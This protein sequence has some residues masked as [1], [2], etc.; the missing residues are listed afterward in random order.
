[1]GE[2]PELVYKLDS[3][4]LIIEVRFDLSNTYIAGLSKSNNYSVQ[5]LYI[6]SVEYEKSATKP[7]RQIP[8]PKGQIPGLQ[9]MN[10][11]TVVLMI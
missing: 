10:L 7:H 9:L 2:N 4:D 3:G 6:S 8:H 5:M 11:P 1:M